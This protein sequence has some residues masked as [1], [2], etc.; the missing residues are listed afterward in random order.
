[1]C[2]CL[3]GYDYFTTY[4]FINE[5]HASSFAEAELE[6]SVLF[7]SVLWERAKFFFLL[8]ILMYAPF[9][10]IVPL[11][12]RCLF[13]FVMGIYMGACMIGL[14]VFGLVVAI[15][16]W[17]PHGFFYLGAILLIFHK[18][19]WYRYS[20]KNVRLRNW[21][22]RVGIILLILVGCMCEVKLGCIILQRLF[23][24]VRW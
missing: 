1:M 13:V 12:F 22:I 21:M 3:F 24:V 16:T 10:K 7:G 5:Y 14:G 8:V 4:G 17:I 23:R 6:F 20:G 19:N 11:I 18:E 2:A 9:K 15:A